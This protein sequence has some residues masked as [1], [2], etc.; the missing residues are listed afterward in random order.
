MSATIER[1]RR[2]ARQRVQRLILPEGD[3]ERALRAAAVLSR[4]RLAEV[5]LGGVPDQ[6]RDRARRAEVGLRGIPVIDASA[7]E[8][9]ERT[10]RGAESKS[11]L[12]AD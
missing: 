6:V 5:A 2:M 4:E 10:A 11:A 3:D 8:E 1:I 9:I 7:S 12:D